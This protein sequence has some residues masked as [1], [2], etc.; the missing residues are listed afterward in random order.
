MTKKQKKLL[1][2]I[3]A[4][5]VLFIA[6][7]A[8]PFEKFNIIPLLAAYA[9]VGYAVIIKAV[10]NIAH[11]QIFDENFLML[12][13]TVGA[14]ILGEY[15]EAVVVM[16]LY[17]VGE[18]FESIAVGR[19]RDSISSLIDLTPECANVLRDGEICEIDP[20]EVQIGDIIVIKSGEKVPLDGVV[21]GGETS[22]DTSA[23]TGESVP[24][25]I[26]TGDEILSGCINIGGTVKVKVT[27]EFENSTVSRIMYLV[28]EATGNKSKSESFITRFAKYYTP[29]VVAAAVLL[30]LVPSIITHDVSK[31]V[32]RALLFL[33][34]SC[35]CALVISVPLGFFCGIGRASKSGILI[36]GSNYLEML[37]KAEIAAFDKTGTLTKGKFCVEE[38]HAVSMSDEE[39]LSLC[40]HAEAYIDHPIAQSVR[41]SFGEKINYEI[42]KDTKQ[43]TGCGVSCVIL[44]KEV[45][46]GNAELMERSSV[47]YEKA[48]TPLTVLY[49]AVGGVYAG[50]IVVADEIKE[51]TVKAVRDMKS[52]GVKKT[53]MLTG[54]NE[55]VGA[56]IGEKA[57]LDTVFGS[58][59]PEDKAQKLSEL[60]KEGIVVYTGDGLNDA[61][62]IAEA[63]I[64]VAMGAMGSDAAIEAAD[65]VIM[66]DN[67][68]KL[69]EAIKI[70]RKTMRLVKENIVFA[71]VI[72]FGVMIL[73]TVGLANMWLAVFADVGVSIIAI[74]NSLRGQK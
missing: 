36:K 48:E 74:L 56:Y 58:L 17:Q 73:G 67:I 11:G 18:L 70:G 33:V 45:L 71:L 34:V 8:L 25:E 4:A 62:V 12:I 24:R 2:K 37:S 61:P 69:P 52:L 44:G 16:L 50:F 51:E 53:V 68:M 64:G 21:T 41:N 1:T 42:V 31:W 49:A 72:K 5:A 55:K 35:P 29:A 40:A 59:L 43:I 66:D 3:I 27:K 32:S 15:D 23:L 14:I 47:A 26:K 57:G 22:L 28:E 10:K 20:E 30:A 63:D 60:K 38:I 7:L 39:L 6:G 46:V 65:V 9:I 13:A 54:D 19:S